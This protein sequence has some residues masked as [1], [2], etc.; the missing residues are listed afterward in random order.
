MLGLRLTFLSGMVSFEI[1]SM[2]PVVQVPVPHP[3]VVATPNMEGT[4]GNNA[5]FHPLLGSMMIGIE[6]DILIKFLKS[7]PPVFQGE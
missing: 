5:F 2:V 1:I 4:L 7:K 6:H 3:I